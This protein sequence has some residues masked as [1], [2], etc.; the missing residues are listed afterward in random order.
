MIP[1]THAVA[2]CRPHRGADFGSAD[3]RILGPVL[4]SEWSP[5]PAHRTGRWRTRRLGTRNR[6]SVEEWI[7]SGAFC[8]LYHLIS[9]ESRELDQSGTPQDARQY[10]TVMAENVIR[11]LDR[12]HIPKANIVSY[13]TSTDAVPYL[14]K[15]HPDRILTN[16]L[17]GLPQQNLAAQNP[18][19][20]PSSVPVLAIATDSNLGRWRGIQVA[21]PQLKLI[22]VRDVGG[23]TPSPQFTRI[24]AAFLHAD[25]ANR[26]LWAER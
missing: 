6:H 8:L 11:L 9:L 7:D 26:N 4:R 10:G 13:G 25:P 3:R 1:T 22:T 17:G 24:L 12:L 14:L 18:G 5:D 2:L 20:F 15:I 21:T 16:V 19:A 23:A